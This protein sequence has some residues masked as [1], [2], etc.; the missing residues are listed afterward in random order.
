[1]RANI[2]L[3]LLL[4]TSVMSTAIA[5]EL[6]VLE[7]N[8]EQGSWFATLEINL[9]KKTIQYDNLMARLAHSQ[10][11]IFSKSLAAKENR[12][13]KPST[14]VPRVWDISSASAS[15]LKAKLNDGELIINRYTM[16]LNV[17]LGEF[18]CERKQ[19]QF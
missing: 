5:E 4:T 13:Y 10:W 15:E 18:K 6:I 3:G 11:N 7:C 12:E 19:K 17:P 1:M 2:V 16:T 8:S 9:Q 14:Y